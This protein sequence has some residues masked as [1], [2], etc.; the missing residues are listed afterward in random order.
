[1][2]STTPNHLRMVL[3]LVSAKVDKDGVEELGGEA[4]VADS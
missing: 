4:A 3:K 1:M 2:K